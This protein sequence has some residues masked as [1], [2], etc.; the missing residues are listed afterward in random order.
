MANFD[1]I[2]E[3]GLGQLLARRLTT[4]GGAVAP[5]VAPELFPVLTLE[6]DRPEWGYLKGE[7]L[8]AR[9]IDVAGVAGQYAM[10]Q[11]YIPS[12]SATIAVIEEIHA[13][14]AS[15]V[16][17]VHLVGIGGGTVGWTALTTGTRDTRAANTQGDSAILE[18][19]SNAALPSFHAVL[20]QINTGGQPSFRQPIVLSPG[21]A[22]CAYGISLGA[23]LSINLVYRSRP[24]QPGETL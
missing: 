14:A 12:N 21:Q 16:N 13:R 18:S 3:F 23:A 17:I 5:T 24:S 20:A 8:R 4:P 9:A 22:I 11:L 1:S 2:G 15:S 6:N 7:Q 19:R 10:I